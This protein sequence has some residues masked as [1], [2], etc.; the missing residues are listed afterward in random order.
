M[1]VSG[2]KFL[3]RIASLLVNVA[4]ALALVG[5]ILFFLLPRLLN[6]DLQ[7]VLSGSMEPALPVGSVAFVRP[8][9]SEAVAVGDIITYH[10]QASPDFVTHRVVE[11]VRE[12]GS[13]SFV[14]KG[15]ANDE[16]DNYIVPADNVVGTVRWAIPYL[17]Y[18]AERLRT[19]QAFLLL[20]AVPGALIIAGEV[21]NI[22]RAL[23]R[24]KSE[25]LGAR[26]G[27]DP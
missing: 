14:T 1:S 3:F 6:W 23:R 7:V 27:R 10:P 18:L 24:G 21:W 12:G 16:P 19:P 11:V 4:V 2:I 25:Q 17:G 22:V 20:V 26:L 8:V 15:D 13:L 5:V 9:D